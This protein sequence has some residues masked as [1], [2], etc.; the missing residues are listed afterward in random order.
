MMFGIVFLNY[1]SKAGGGGGS[2]ET[3]QQWAEDGSL[4]SRSSESLSFHSD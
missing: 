1:T 4:R 2:E 3:K